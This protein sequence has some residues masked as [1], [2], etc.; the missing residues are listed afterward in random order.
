MKRNYERADDLAIVGP[1]RLYSS[2]ISTW[3]DLP[4]IENESQLTV[5]LLDRSLPH[6]SRIDVT[7]PVTGSSV[8]AK[9]T[10]QSSYRDDAS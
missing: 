10:V 6:S 7:T 5:Q 4:I 1:F 8:G 9:M 2:R 3:H